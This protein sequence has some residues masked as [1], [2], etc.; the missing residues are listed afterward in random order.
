MKDFKSYF[1]KIGSIILLTMNITL[2]KANV[3]TEYHFS[4]HMGTF[5]TIDSTVGVNYIDTLGFGSWDDGGSAVLPIGFNF[6][7]GGATRNSFVATTNGNINFNTTPPFYSLWEPI[8]PNTIQP[9][10]I[11]L[12]NASSLYP[13]SR[14]FHGTGKLMYKTEG[15]SPNRVLTVE[16]KNYK[17]YVGMYNLGA[18]QVKLYETTNRIEFVYDT[19][20]NLGN[21]VSVGI[22][23]NNDV[24]PFDVHT[25]TNTTNWNTTYR[26]N[27]YG[28]MNGSIT[29]R[30]DYG[31]VYVWDH[32]SNIVT[33]KIS[34]YLYHDSNNNCIQDS[35]EAGIPNRQ[36]K[37]LP[38]NYLTHTDVNG[39]YEYFLD[40]MGDY[41]IYP[42]LDSVIDIVC[43]GNDTLHVHVDSFIN[44]V[45]FPIHILFNC[46]SLKINSSLPFL[47]SCRTSFINVSYSNDGIVAANNVEIKVAIDPEIIVTGST[48]PWL[49]IDSNV[50]VFYFSS[51]P[52]LSS[53][54]IRIF[55]SIRCSSIVGQTA[56]VHANI[57]ASNICNMVDS[58]W[59]SSSVA[60]YAFCDSSGTN[61]SIHFT[62]MNKSLHDMSDSS[63]Y[64]LYEDDLLVL[65]RRFILNANEE[66]IVRIP[67]TGKTF[68]LEADQV[69]HHPGHS[70]PRQFV[71]LCGNP[72][73]S[74]NQIMPYPMDDIDN[75]VDIACREIAL[76]PR[77]VVGLSY[78]P[79]LKS[80]SPA[81]AGSLHKIARDIPLEYTIEFQNTGTAPASKV[82]LLD[83]IDISKLQINTIDM[84]MASHA[85]RLDILGSNV[86]RWTFDPI[87]LPDSGLDQTGSHG[88]VKFTLMPVSGLPNLTRIN[89]YAEIYFDYNS[90]VRT[91]THFVTIADEPYT[92][93]LPLL[94]NKL[95][96][97]NPCYGD[98]IATANLNVT[99]GTGHYTVLWSDGNTALTRTDLAAGIYRYTVTDWYGFT[100]TDSVKITT[101]TNF[102]VLDTIQN[103]LCNAASNGA[104]N[105]FVSGATPNY[106]YLWNDGST[107]KNRSSLD[108]GTYRLLI[109]DANHC[110]DSFT[111]SITEPT[112][113]SL[114]ESIEE[115][116]CNGAST[117]SI[118]LTLSGATP[119]YSYL[120]NDGA[121]NLDRMSLTAGIYTVTI[122]DA[123]GCEKN[124]SFTITQPDELLVNET[125]TDAS[126]YGTADGSIDISVSGGTLPYDYS[127]NSGSSSED[128]SGVVANTY[129]VTVEDANGCITNQSIVVSQPSG[130]DMADLKNLINVFPNP[131]ASMIQIAIKNIPIDAI[132]LSDPLNKQV[133]KIINPKLNEL[134]IDV[135]NLAN[136]IY[137]LNIQSYSKTISYQ[138]NIQH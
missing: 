98:E 54:A 26:A 15:V 44:N 53:G 76:E 97:N 79:N 77:V 56:C 24:N 70:I 131:S 51:I 93:P 121:N 113:F 108:V 20:T 32:D 21:Q 19:I 46:N 66:L 125:H 120:W 92:L 30:P 123:N 23:G 33:Y 27:S 61:D 37:L 109:T 111:Y 71:E 58:A 3:G 12:Y 137:T 11:D 68:R 57:E 124:R 100:I 85:Y 118:D 28:K 16:W 67:A 130:L 73:Y 2:M 102:S 64:R 22:S 133:R 114:T 62:I 49:R 42:L 65:N 31:L 129:S 134:Q 83:T 1:L 80:S 14:F 39:Y 17:F 107:S 75:W 96:H 10:G 40:S 52:P 13:Y 69:A 115:V 36:V 105:L 110:I 132:T 122:T 78:D 43:V 84:Q 74:L 87:Y 136:G 55:D 99:R 59:D 29:N 38:T 6:I 4:A 103:V 8:S 34:G 48:V 50:Y 81:G 106:S 104:I 126:S 41:D 9:F 138:I 116:S 94:V 90:P 72:P 7:Y 60:V 63:S 89:N 101:P 5:N 18:F 112:V 35:G 91:N 128:L 117:G 86:L 82:V 88:F 95:S 45:N 135:T 25:R 127:W 47:I 119:G